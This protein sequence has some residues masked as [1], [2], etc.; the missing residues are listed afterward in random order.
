MERTLEMPVLKADRRHDLDALRAFA[1]LLGIG[2]HAALSF[3]G[4][5]WLVT[6]NQN[7]VAFHWFIEAVHGFRMQLF[8]LV[9]GYFTALLLA[10]RGLGGMLKNRAA[11]ILVPCL[12]GLATLI[13][14]MPVILPLL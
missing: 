1:M 10:R 7:S 13:P 9:S 2:Y 14:G 6:D 11:R 4:T 5:P 3:G 8:F 12:L